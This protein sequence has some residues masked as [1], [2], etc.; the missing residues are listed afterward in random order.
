M[1]SADVFSI[2]FG[3]LPV[4]SRVSAAVVCRDWYEISAYPHH[5]TLVDFEICVRHNLLKFAEYYKGSF[6]TLTFLRKNHRPE[7]MEL[8]LSYHRGCVPTNLMRFVMK[9][10]KFEVFMSILDRYPD[11]MGVLEAAIMYDRAKIC[12]ALLNIHPELKLPNIPYNVK[13]IGMLKLFMDKNP[14]EKVISTIT[15]CVD[16]HTYFLYYPQIAE[17]AGKH[18]MN[19]IKYGLHSRLRQVLDRK[20][21]T[22][23]ID[24]YIDLAVITGNIDIVEMLL[25]DDRFNP[26]QNNCSAL[27]TAIIKQ[28]PISIVKMLVNDHRIN[29][30]SIINAI[31]DTKTW[32]FLNL[33]SDIIKR[34]QLAETN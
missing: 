33:F 23:P 14:T 12:R 19:L 5:W 10:C 25:N 27:Y 13:N 34:K 3:Y 9:Y 17:R 21:L 28:A 4:Q 24:N 22:F 30:T 6:D 20:E 16:L 2:I 18:V 7:M 29:S 15:R 1:F 32:A 31:V 11:K 26:Q 8:L